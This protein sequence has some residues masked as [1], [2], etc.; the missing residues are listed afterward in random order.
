MNAAATTNDTRIRILDIAEQLARQRGFSGFSYRDISQPL[1]I[2][3]AAIHYHFPTKADLGVALLTRYEELLS[4]HTSEFM[5][6]GGCAL[7]QLEGFIA[8]YTG[9][10]CSNQGTCLIA[11]L[12]SEFVTVPAAMQEAGRSL[13]LSIQTWMTKVLDIGREQGELSFEGDPRDKALLILTSLQ[14]ASQMARMTGPATMDAAVRQI[15]AD[16]GIG[17][18]S[19]RTWPQTEAVG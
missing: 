6:H 16:L 5:E 14:G 19:A 11:M 10:I 1:G 18:E 2:K 3:N 13:S 4:R 17:H 9:K 15:R 8:F 12:A 7:D